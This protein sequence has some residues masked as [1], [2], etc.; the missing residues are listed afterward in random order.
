MMLLIGDKLKTKTNN[1]LSGL[2]IPFCR[3]T[4]KQLEGVGEI[5]GH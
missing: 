3:R 5:S 4:R 1:Q 2:A